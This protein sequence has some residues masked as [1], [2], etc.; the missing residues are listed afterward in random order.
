MTEFTPQPQPDNELRYDP[1]AGSVVMPAD[2]SPRAGD[3]PTPVHAA[4]RIGAI[5]VADGIRLG[6][7]V[8]WAAASGHEVTVDDAGRVQ[9]GDQAVAIDWDK[10]E[11]ISDGLTAEQEI[12]A[13]ALDAA[14]RLGIRPESP[15][16]GD[17][18]SAAGATAV[19][20]ARYMRFLTDGRPCT[21]LAEHGAHPHTAR[22]CDIAHCGCRWAPP[23]IDD[24]DHP[25]EP[26]ADAA[27]ED[28]DA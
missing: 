6:Y 4:L 14:T 11:L 10:F 23:P 5:N 16:A 28:R 7:R 12:R 3:I 18:A 13:R 26:W 21:C 19:I 1:A 2:W 9:I 15:D 27:P 22:G 25:D 20:A 8:G 24:P 17:E